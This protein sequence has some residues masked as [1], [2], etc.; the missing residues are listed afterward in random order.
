MDLKANPELQ[1][2]LQEVL[3]AVGE[4][5]HQGRISHNT[6]FCSPPR[7]MGGPSVPKAASESRNSSSDYNWDNLIQIQRQKLNAAGSHA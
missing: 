2:V 6:P 5:F 1:G 7:V 4:E 3:N